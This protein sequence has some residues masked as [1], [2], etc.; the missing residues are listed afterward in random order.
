MFSHSTKL[1]SERVG[2]IFKWF[3]DGFFAIP[4]SLDDHFE[5]S[6]HIRLKSAAAFAVLIANLGICF[7]CVVRTPVRANRSTSNSLRV[8]GL[9]PLI[10]KSRFEACW[11]FV[12]SVRA[13]AQPSP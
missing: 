5:L 4:N 2:S 11:R 6:M 10:G 8:F 1:I 12:P 7:R 9:R 13:L 3:A